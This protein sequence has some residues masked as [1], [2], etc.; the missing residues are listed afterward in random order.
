MKATA[1]VCFTPE[2]LE[3]RIASAAFFLHGNTLAIPDGGGTPVTNDAP[4]LAAAAAWAKTAA[5][6][7][8][9]LT[10]SSS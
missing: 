4:E 2:I 5:A 6:R 1:S 3:T 10:A 7:A 8:T 9:C